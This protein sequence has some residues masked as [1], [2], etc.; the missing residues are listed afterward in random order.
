MIS[1][2]DVP[3]IQD[4]I[5]DS[6]KL[7]N[8]LVNHITNEKGEILARVWENKGFQ[9]IYDYKGVELTRRR[10]KR[11]QEQV[12]NRFDASTHLFQK[13]YYN[14]EL[15]AQDE[16]QLRETFIKYNNIHDQTQNFLRGAF[17]LGYWPLTYVVARKISP[18]GVFLYS[19]AYLGA[20]KYGAKAFAL[21]T[22]QGNLNRHAEDLAKKY[23]IKKPD[24]YAQ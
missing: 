4:R 5:Y 12:F 1:P 13:V 21:G 9:E 22:L 3:I 2:Q 19:L 8:A 11:K 6:E 10:L 24:E 14:P 7:A 20:Y 16:V 15:L 17:F 18:A 23:G